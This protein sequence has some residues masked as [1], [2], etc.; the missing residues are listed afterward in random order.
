MKNSDWRNLKLSFQNCP[1]IVFFLHFILHSYKHAHIQPY[2]SSS[3]G[4]KTRK[5]IQKGVKSVLESSGRQ[6]VV[7][8]PLLSD[9]TPGRHSGVCAALLSLFCSDPKGSAWCAGAIFRPLPT[10]V[11]LPGAHWRTGTVTALLTLKTRAFRKQLFTFFIK[12]LGCPVECLFQSRFS[13]KK[14]KQLD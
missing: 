13:K 7:L 4:C 5:L 8:S 12:S 2:T 9:P 6:T 3:W 1:P 11:S 10:P 14:E